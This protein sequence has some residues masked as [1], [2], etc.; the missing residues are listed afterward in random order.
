MLRCIGA[1]RVVRATARDGVPGMAVVNDG[2]QRWTID[3]PSSSQYEKDADGEWVEWDDVTALL[4]ERDEARTEADTLLA[5][6]ERLRAAVSRIR[7]W[8][9]TY[10]HALVPCAG[11]ADTYGDGVRACKGQVKAILG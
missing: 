6:C 5:E 11:A 1:R 2:V 10:G 4:W 3:A 9:D 7:V 8:A